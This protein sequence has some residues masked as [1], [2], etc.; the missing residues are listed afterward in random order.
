[1]PIFDITFHPSYRLLSPS[2]IAVPI[3]IGSQALP[4][5]DRSFLALK[6]SANDIRDIS[7]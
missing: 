6:D 3:N 2:P 7:N 4:W 1:M 5:F